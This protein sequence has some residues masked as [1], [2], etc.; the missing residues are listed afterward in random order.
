M[1][2]V[3]FCLNEKCKK[4]TKFCLICYFTNH[5]NHI[6]DCYPFYKIKEQIL[7]ILYIW[8]ELSVNYPNDLLAA[9]T[10]IIK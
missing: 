3:G 9:Y 1:N 4:N 6:K 7:H 10:N 2:I 8:A 5:S